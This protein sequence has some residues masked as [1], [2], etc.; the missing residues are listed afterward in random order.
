MLCGNFFLS[1]NVLRHI[2]DVIKPKQHL[3][4]FK[5]NDAKKIIEER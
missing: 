4:E 5:E 1:L 2:L 3:P